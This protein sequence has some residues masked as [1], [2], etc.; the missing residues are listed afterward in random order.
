[1]EKPY[2]DIGERL[3]LIEKAMQLSGA[4]IA[5]RTQ[6]KI[7]PS[8]WS[9]YKQGVRQITV[10]NAIILRDLT[11]ATLDYIYTGDISSLPVR[12][13]EAIQNTTP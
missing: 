2:K 11:G 10:E 9:E 1:M 7:T 4:D 6:G 13:A 3:R 5:R 8:R 12:L